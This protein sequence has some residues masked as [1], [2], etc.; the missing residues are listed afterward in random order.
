V[1]Q[2]SFP[3]RFKKLFFKK[4]LEESR[5]EPR[6]AGTKYGV[7][8]VRRKPARMF[9]TSGGKKCAIHPVSC[10]SYPC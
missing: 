10:P 8:N 9:M 4:L 2:Q 7:K 6:L 5:K 1:K 3:E